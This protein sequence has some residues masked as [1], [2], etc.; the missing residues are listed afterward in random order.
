MFLL[1]VESQTLLKKGNAG[2]YIKS[3]DSIMVR[4]E[5]LAKVLNTST[6]NSLLSIMKTELIVKNSTKVIEVF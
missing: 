4:E 2:V 3:V 1:Q 6:T 5:K